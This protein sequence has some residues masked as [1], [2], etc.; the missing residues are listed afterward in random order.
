ML[1]G[2][3]LPHEPCNARCG[4][5]NTTMENNYDPPAALPSTASRDS[6]PARDFVHLLNNQLTVVL[7]HAETSLGSDDPQE[8]RRALQAILTAS[9]TMADAVR[10]FSHAIPRPASA[11][12]AMFDRE[13]S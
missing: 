10:A 5:A 4:P 8:L 3:Q 7:A 12:R 11:A 13:A 9:N 2:R 6:S 1:S